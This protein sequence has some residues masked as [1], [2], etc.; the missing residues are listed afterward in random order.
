MSIALEQAFFEVVKNRKAE[1]RNFHTTLSKNSTPWCYSR[2]AVIELD[3]STKLDLWYIWC[4]SFCSFHKIV[5]QSCNGSTQEVNKSSSEWR[6]SYL[7]WF[8]LKRSKLRHILIK[9]IK[10]IDKRVIKYQQS[11]GLNG[12]LLCWSFFITILFRWESWSNFM[13]LTLL[14]K[15]IFPIPILMFYVAQKLSQK[16]Q[17]LTNRPSVLGIYLKTA[18]SQIMQEMP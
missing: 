8:S 9:K 6:L 12:W 2:L 3:Y 13:N 17:N 15:T 18:Y 1:R 14:V 5:F 7:V 11:F 10:L 16:T 4:L